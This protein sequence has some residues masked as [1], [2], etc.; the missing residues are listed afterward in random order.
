MGRRILAFQIIAQ[1][2]VDRGLVVTAAGALHLSAEIFQDVA[3]QPDGDTL[4][5][6]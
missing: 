4:L 1:H 3:I 5:A 2:L 6:G